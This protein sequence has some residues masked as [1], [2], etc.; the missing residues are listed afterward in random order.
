VGIS[1]AQTGGSDAFLISTPVYVPNYNAGTP[2]ASSW[3]RSTGYD[4]AKWVETVSGVAEN[5]ADAIPYLDG[6]SDFNALDYTRN[7]TFV[8]DAERNTDAMYLGKRGDICQYIG[9]TAP[10]TE[11]GKKLKG[12]R[13]PTSSEFGTVTE[14]WDGTTPK[15]GGWMPTV[16]TWTVK[17]ATAGNP[18]GT[19]NLLESAKNNAGKVFAAI[20]NNGMGGVVLPASGL[21]IRSFLLDWVG[22]TGYYVSG[23]AANEICYWRMHFS[24]G[25]GVGIDI[26]TDRAFAISV[27][28]VRN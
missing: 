13:L 17:D 23:S 21:R 28:C 26:Q 27:R 5:D 15:G 2:S 14:N 19:A 3:V 20:Q 16:S 4:P 18:E 7:N 8:I 11:E 10:N 24:G 22:Q 9:K 6:R 12:F 1:P 25:S